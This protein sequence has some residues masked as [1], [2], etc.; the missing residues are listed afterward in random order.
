MIDAVRVREA[1]AELEAAARPVGDKRVTAEEA[2]RLVSDGDHVAIGG[3]CYSRGPM[4][5]VF[6]MLRAQPR[7]LTV[8]R[9]LSSYEVDLLLASGVADKIVTSWVGIGLQWGL[10]QVL[11]HYVE[12]GLA[13]YEE[14]S[15]LAIGLRYKAG[16][17][18]VPF[19]P[20]LSMLGSDMAAAVSLKTVS[21][22]YTD[23][24]LAAIPAVNPD[25][26]LIHAHRA[27]RFG[28]TQVDGYR[29]MDSDMARAARK[30]IVSAERIVSTDEI[31][32]RPWTTMLPHFAVDAVVEAPFGAYPNECY[33]L[34]DADFAH[35]DDYVR[36]VKEQGVDGARSYVDGN[37][38]EVADFAGFLRRVGDERLNALCEEARRLLPR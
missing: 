18:G 6:A 17:M 28:N 38:R 37:V 9:P 12:G 34:Y 33:G 4:A 23:E 14:W 36:L 26:A 10:S 30:V 29:H 32:S 35:F 13:V 31:S 22:P 25:V 3:T 8:S 21:C 19:L 7:R 27:D 20:V 1:R 11:R 16:A 2:V 15:H 24:Q 5:L